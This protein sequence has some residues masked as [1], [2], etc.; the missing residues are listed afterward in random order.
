[1]YGQDWFG[2]NKKNQQFG[3]FPRSVVFAQ[4]NHAV[5][6]ASAVTPQK[7]P[8]A[9]T[10]RMRP[11]PVIQ[12]PPPLPFASKPLNNNT[13]TSYNDRTS[14]ISMPVAAAPTN[15][16][17]S[18]IRT[19]SLD[20]PEYDDFDRA[21]DDGFSPSKIEMPR[22]FAWGNDIIISNGNRSEETILIKAPERRDPTFDIRGNVLKPIPIEKVQPPTSSRPILVA[23]TAS[24]VISMPLP[25]KFGTSQPHRST[26][27]VDKP[28]TSRN[29]PPRHNNSAGSRLENMGQPSFLNQQKQNIPNNLI[30]ELQSRL[31]GGSD[32]MMRPR[33]AS[34]IGILN[35]GM[36]N[37]Y[38]PQINRPFSV[39]NV[40]S[41]PQQPAQIPCLVPTP[42]PHQPRKST[43]Q[44]QNPLQKALADELK[45]IL[46]RRPT[47]GGNASNGLPRATQNGAGMPLS[48]P[49]LQPQKV[50]QP[51]ISQQPVVQKPIQQ[52]PG[53]ARPASVQPQQVK[54]PPPAATTA[55]ATT[56]TTS[57]PL[58]PP[59]TES[60][61]VSAPAPIA[62]TTTS[63]TTS[64]SSLVTR[65]STQ[66][67][68]MSEEERRSRI[69][70]DVA[71]AL[72]APSALLLGS[73]STS[74]IPSTTTQS[75]VKDR[76]V[77]AQ[78]KPSQ[79]QPT[80]PFEKIEA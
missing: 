79:P 55:T 17:M 52:Q 53:Q 38:N 11:E 57:R 59:A 19:L 69:I 77:A 40:P 50:Q 63:A 2:Q 23:P 41:M 67:I 60:R 15:P 4:T 78:V 42:A 26:A 16:A 80:M 24:G 31:N 56:T 20:L 6:A 71:S 12:A 54:L 48:Q 68:T 3:T 64:A 58:A 75:A 51:V 61:K 32:N 34:S 74:A 35:N 45:G 27:Y 30:P 1:M 46:S 76:P 62:P 36:E 14:R 22:G 33:P 47:S 73:N 70:Q 25:E 65:R 18:K 9:P 28:D 5:A 39:V 21:F 37:A 13:K 66:T 8:T 43:N 49:A 29:E 44:E 7:V 72:P 10:I